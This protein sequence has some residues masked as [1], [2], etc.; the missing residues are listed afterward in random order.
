MTEDG[1]WKVATSFMAD[2]SAERGI[3]H[4]S[5]RLNRISGPSVQSPTT[6]STRKQILEGIPRIE[7]IGAIGG[8]KIIISEREQL[9]TYQR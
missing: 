7:M 8:Q 4:H 1:W 9:D 5:I 3:L 6:K 2:Q